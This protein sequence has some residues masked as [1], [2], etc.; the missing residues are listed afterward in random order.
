MLEFENIEKIFQYI[1]RSGVSG[2]KQKLSYRQIK[3]LMKN[4][5]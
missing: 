2:G 3:N 1:K 5:R 4:Y